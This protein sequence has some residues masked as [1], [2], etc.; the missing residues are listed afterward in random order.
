MLEQLGL[1]SAVT[2]YTTTN[3]TPVGQVLGAESFHFTLPLKKGAKGDEVTQLQNF[4][5]NAGYDCGTADGKFGPKTK[6]ALIKFEIANKLKGDGVVGP[7]VRAIL[8]Q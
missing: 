5:N 4:L 7:K 3:T 6:T 2:T 8:N 1:T